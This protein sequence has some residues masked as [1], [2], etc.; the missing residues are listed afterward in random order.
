MINTG[1]DPETGV[2][3]LGGKANSNIIPIDLKVMQE[4][5]DADKAVKEA[6]ALGQ[7]FGYQLLL[8][9]GTAAQGAQKAVLAEKNYG[10]VLKS[11]AMLHGIDLANV[12][13]VDVEKG[14]IILK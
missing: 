14:Q 5:R 3:I 4:L 10:D 6:R 8:M 1:R 13:D 12:A 9:I 11:I 7:V 2:P